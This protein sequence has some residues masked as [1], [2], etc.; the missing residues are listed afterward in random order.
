MAMFASASGEA[1]VDYEGAHPDQLHQAWLS[2]RAYMRANGI[3]DRGDLWS[4]KHTL[5]CS[6]GSV[7]SL[8]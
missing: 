6:F 2:I 4:Y 1:G 5:R 8:R 3:S 7:L